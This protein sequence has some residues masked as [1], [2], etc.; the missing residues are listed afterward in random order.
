MEELLEEER[1]ITKRIE[2]LVDY[3]ETL[4]PEINSLINRVGVLW[5]NYSILT[6]EQQSEFSDK[7]KKLVNLRNK[8]RLEQKKELDN[9]YSRLQE[10]NNKKLEL[11]PPIIQG[12]RLELKRLNDD[13]CGEYI[14]LLKDTNTVVGSI[15]Y[16]GYHYSNFLADIGFTINVD[17]RGNGYAYES[18][19]L[20]SNILY[21]NNINDFW[22]TAFR[23]NQASIKTILKYGATELEGQYNNISFYECPTRKY[24][25]KNNEVIR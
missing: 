16:R 22:I 10:I 19:C 6:L 8:I 24:I 25:Y 4:S 11:T 1:K 14:V 3:D 18:L 9:L 17:Y 21:D 23:D 2:E 5:K 7:S 15:S 13:I 12:D 20:L